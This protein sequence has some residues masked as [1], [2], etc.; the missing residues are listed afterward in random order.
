MTGL[1]QREDF[2]DPRNVAAFNLIQQTQKLN[3]WSDAMKP[4]YTENYKNRIERSFTK[5]LLAIEIKEQI[6]N[7]NGD[8]DDT[9]KSLQ[10]ITLRNCLPTWDR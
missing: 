4:N 1:V 6:A 9:D 2:H 5:L 7:T 10:V 8:D 3:E